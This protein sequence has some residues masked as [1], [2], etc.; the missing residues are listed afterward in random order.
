MDPDAAEWPCIIQALPALPP[1]PSSSGAL[2]LPTMVQALPA[3]TEPPL[4]AASA[5]RSRARRSEPPSPRRTRSGGA[6]E[7]T[8]AETLALVAEVAAVD[9]GWSRSVSAFQKWAIVAEN[10]AYSPASRG[11]ARGRGR[12]ASECRRRWEM[13]AAEY[14]AVRRWEVRGGGGYWGMSATARRKAG[15][16]ADFDA[17]VY[18]AMEALTL[19]EEALLADTAIAAA[20]EEVQGLVGAVGSG[21]GADEIGQKSAGEAGEA[22]EGDAVKQDEDDDGGEEEE[23]EE[24]DGNEMVEEEDDDNDNDNDNEGTQVDGGNATASDGGLVSETEENNELNKSQIDGCQLA[25]KL[26]ENAQHIHMLLKEEA[27]EGQNHNIAISSDAMETTRQKADELIKSLGGLVS[28]L[29]QFTDLI[30]ENGFE[31]VVGMS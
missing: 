5:S 24:E 11:K 8:P 12:A 2:R 26:Q 1:S 14:G 15:L 13:L 9:D 20:G 23:E 19:V 30:K 4:A 18:G 7:W 3:A 29:N 6:P 27:G 31:N 28:Y 22:N 21:S 25:N 10:L 17:E 16:P